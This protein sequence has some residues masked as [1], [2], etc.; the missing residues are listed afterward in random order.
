MNTQELRE[1]SIE[2]LNSELLS[3]MKEHFNLRMQRGVGQFPKTHLFNK[4]KTD[5]ARIKTIIHEKGSKE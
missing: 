1:K 3:L 4:V 5:I 2:E